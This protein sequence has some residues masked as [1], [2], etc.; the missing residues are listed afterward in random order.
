[1]RLTTWQTVLQSQMI[2]PDWNVETHLAYLKQEG[3]SL[4]RLNG[5]PEILITRWLAENRA[6]GRI[7]NSGL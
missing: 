5:D 4:H 3:A 7:A 2:H 1:M 6:A